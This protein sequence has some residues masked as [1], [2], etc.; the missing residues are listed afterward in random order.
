MNSV[1]SQKTVGVR[2]PSPPR[3]W[4]PEPRRRGHR[5]RARVRFALVRRRLYP[6]DPECRM[7]APSPPVV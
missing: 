1:A 6:A 3:L 4:I 5:Q 2:S 7:V